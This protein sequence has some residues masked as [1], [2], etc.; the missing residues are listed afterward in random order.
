MSKKQI[1]IEKYILPS[2]IDSFGTEY[3]HNKYGELHSFLGQPA[4]VNYNGISESVS[5]KKIEQ[6][7]WYKNGK[8]HRERGLPAIIY[9]YDDKISTRYWF[10]N[11]ET[12]RENEKCHVESYVFDEINKIKKTHQYWMEDGNVS[13]YEV[14]KYKIK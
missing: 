14:K 1:L 5:Y 7:R 11:G 8:T 4:V 9:F 3:W 2:E 10:K 13:K 6:Q 12:Y